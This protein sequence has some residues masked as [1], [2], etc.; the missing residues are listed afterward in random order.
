[1]DIGKSIGYVFEDKKWTNKLLIGALVSIVPIVNFA[2]AG[3]WTIIMRNVTERNPT[4]LPEWDNFGDKFIKGLMLWLAGLIYSI[5][6]LILFCPLAILP[7]FSGNNQ[8]GRGV[9]GGL[10]AGTA[11]LLTCIV[12]LYILLVSFLFPAINLNFA[13]KGSFASLFEFGQIWPIMSRN[14]SDYIVA[15]LIAIVIA[16]AASFVIG[17]IAGVIAIVPCIGWLISW[18]LLAATT[19]WVGTVYAHLFGQVGAESPGQSVIPTG[20]A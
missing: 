4:P 5:P 20:Q 16:V 2:F 11:L 14:L 3:Y 6:A 8:D 9:L 18:L 19:V 7:F 17:L 1:M 13:R 15:W 12:G 10:F